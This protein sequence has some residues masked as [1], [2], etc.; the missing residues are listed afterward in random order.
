MDGLDDS[1]ISFIPSSKWK[2]KI[3]SKFIGWMHNKW[4]DDSMYSAPYCPASFLL[5]DCPFSCPRCV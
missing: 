4:M 3:D 1:H 2:T 5:P